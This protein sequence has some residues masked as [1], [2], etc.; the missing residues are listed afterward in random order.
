[1]SAW[2][3]ITPTPSVA[4]GELALDALRFLGRAESGIANDDPEFG[5]LGEKM[6]PRP[7]SSAE[8]RMRDAALSCLTELFNSDACDLDRVPSQEPPP[9]GAG[10]T[11]PVLV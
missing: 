5:P 6:A 2:H 7:L 3:K 4:R 10:Q 9:A 8:M 1:M 11:A